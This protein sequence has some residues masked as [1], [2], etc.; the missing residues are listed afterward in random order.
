MIADMLESW[1]HGFLRSK[2]MKGGGLLMVKS[3]VITAV[4][5]GETD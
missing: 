1:D 2:S 5:F 4:L 3:I